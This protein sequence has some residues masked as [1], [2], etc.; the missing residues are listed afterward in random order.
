MV[1]E[2]GTIDLRYRVLHQYSERFSRT[3]PTVSTSRYLVNVIDPAARQTQLSDLLDLLDLLIHVL[4]VKISQ[5]QGVHSDF[6]TDD[7]NRDI[8]LLSYMPGC[9]AECIRDRVLSFRG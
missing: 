2:S 8:G 3:T 7:C 5:L 6:P 1:Q 9:R 4:G